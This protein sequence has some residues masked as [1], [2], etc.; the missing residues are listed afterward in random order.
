MINPPLMDS[1]ISSRLTMG[2]FIITLTSTI[3]SFNVYSTDVV[4]KKHWDIIILN[5]S[6]SFNVQVYFL[7]F[8]FHS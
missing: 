1:Q 5:F 3:P 4:K 2:L 7:L 6:R 8:S